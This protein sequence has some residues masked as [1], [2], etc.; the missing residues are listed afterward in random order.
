MCLTTGVHTVVHLKHNKLWCMFKEISKMHQELI[1][2]CDKHLAY[3][4]FG[5]FLKLNERPPP[6]NILGTVSGSDPETQQLLLVS[7]S[8]QI[9][10]EFTGTTSASMDTASI[11]ANINSSTFRK[12]SA[13]AGSEAQLKRLES[14]M[15]SDLESSCQPCKQP[16]VNIL[17]GK[18]THHYPTRN[19][20]IPNI[21][22]HNMTLFYRN[23]MCR[24]LK[25]YSKLPIAIRSEKV[26]TKFEKS[27][28]M[29]LLSI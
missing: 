28:K 24:S 3:F 22:Q 20:C 15:K 12:A 17:Q 10:P 19:R 27:L 11:I 9:K 21:Q 5:I 7:V 14:E 29:Y 26:I 2:W 1:K 18:K 4:G 13:G 8:K 16:M 25:D 23:F 6:L